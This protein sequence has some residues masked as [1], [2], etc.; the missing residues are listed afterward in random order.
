M[1]P[2]AGRLLNANGSAS[3]NTAV[4]TNAL[5]VAT[6]GTNTAIGYSALSALT[7][8]TRNT[9][10]GYNAGNA[11]ANGN[12]VTFLGAFANASAGGFS[13]SM[14]LGDAATVN[15]SNKIRLG[16]GATSVIEGQVAYSFPSDG[17]FKTNVKEDV[18]GLDF[19]MKLRPI[20]YNWQTTKY[21]E[22]IGTDKK[23]LEEK[24]VLYKNA[25]QIVQ[26]GFIAQEVEKAANEI[27]YNFNGVHKP[28][29][30]KDNYSVSYDLFIPSL[31]KAIQEQQQ[32]IINQQKMI[33]DL[34]KRVE[35]L[36]KK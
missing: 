24:A 23:A 2:L 16:D 36:E 20:T 12:W 6:G 29:N 15:A 31:T 33:D 13:N 26:T 32:L 3:F 1:W 21:A 35:K 5:L 25:E 17:R 9:A 11:F 27:G 22:F 8:S 14:A 30:P 19:I 10:V 34:L 4:G 28:T 7:T 18:K